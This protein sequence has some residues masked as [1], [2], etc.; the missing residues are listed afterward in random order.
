MHM[1]G[2]CSIYIIGMRKFLKLS[3]I[4]TLN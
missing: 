1:K 2:E 4:Q 3:I